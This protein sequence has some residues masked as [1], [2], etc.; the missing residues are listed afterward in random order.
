MAKAAET[1]QEPAEF[2]VTLREFL[3]EIPDSIVETKTA[4]GQ[5][6]A[7]MGLTGA[8]LRCEWAELMEKFKS[9]PLNVALKIWFDKGGN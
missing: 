4:F 8:K 5:T 3:Q 1:Q 6:C 2:Q 7:D 9:R